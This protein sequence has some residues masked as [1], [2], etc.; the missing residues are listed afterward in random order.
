MFSVKNFL[1]QALRSKVSRSPATFSST[2]WNFL[3]TQ[4]AASYDS[5]FATVFNNDNKTP[6][7]VIRSL[8]TPICVGLT[9]AQYLISGS[10]E[11]VKAM[12]YGAHMKKAAFFNTLN[13]ATYQACRALGLSPSDC[14]KQIIENLKF[15]LGP[16]S[17]HIDFVQVLKRFEEGLSQIKALEKEKPTLNNAEVRSR[18]FNEL[19]S[20]VSKQMRKKLFEHDGCIDAPVAAISASEADPTGT[21][22]EFT[23]TIPIENTIKE[24]ISLGEARNCQYNHM[25]VL[26]AF[27]ELLDAYNDACKNKKV[28]RM[29]QSF[30]ESIGRG[31]NEAR[32]LANVDP[33]VLKLDWRVAE[34]KN[35][36]GIS[37]AAMRKQWLGESAIRNAKLIAELTKRGFSFLRYD[38][39]G[40]GLPEADAVVEARKALASGNNKYSPIAE[41]D[42]LDALSGFYSETSAGRKFHPSEV[43]VLGVR[44]KGALPWMLDFVGQGPV[45][46]PRPTY[47]PNPSAALYH[48]REVLSFDITGPHRYAPMIE[49]LAKHK[50]GGLIVLPIIG[51]PYSTILTEEEEQGFIDVLRSNKV[52]GFFGDHAYRGYNTHKDDTGKIQYIAPTRDVMEKGGFYDESPRDPVTGEMRNFRVTTHSSSKLFNDAS[53]CGTVAAHKHTISF[54]GD[55][56]RG[57]FTQAHQRDRRTIPA[58]VENIDFDAPRR[59]YGAM[60]AF[61]KIVDGKVPGFRDLGADCPPF[62]T[63]DATEWLRKHDLHPE[64]A[65]HYFMSRSPGLCGIFGGFGPGSNEIFRLGFTGEAPERAPLCAEKFI[66]YANDDKAI[67][68]F[69]AKEDELTKVF[70]K[71]LNEIQEAENA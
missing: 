71:A 8:T 29:P 58:I 46:V 37:I 66:E 40:V 3:S 64:E 59:W 56:L 62:K 67:A 63:W 44:A 54:L 31:E 22:G 70:Y 28:F 7:L 30:F 14:A 53:G 57:S 38:V 17:K 15:V 52:M 69:K 18:M 10:K 47:N 9:T 55:M 19:S 34:M 20:S 35:T 68:M 50:G 49:A 12:S 13:K 11:D 24:I 26:I 27:D 21:F 6:E 2:K 32:L 25:D 61:N 65:Q 48:S 39:G 60:E 16:S 43:M 41:A 1:R 45:F 42:V 5:V 23:P 4:A 51:N 36:N 33:R